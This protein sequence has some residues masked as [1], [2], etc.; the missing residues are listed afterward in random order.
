MEV[1]ARLVLGF[2]GFVYLSVRGFDMGLIAWMAWMAWH[3]GML[4]FGGRVRGIV[5]FSDIVADLLGTLL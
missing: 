5:I 1:H 4:S 3:D 2:L